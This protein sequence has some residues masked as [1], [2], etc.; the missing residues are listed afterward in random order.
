MSCPGQRNLNG[1]AECEIFMKGNATAL[2]LCRITETMPIKMVDHE[3]PWHPLSLNATHPSLHSQLNN[4]V[5]VAASR[6]KPS[7]SYQ[8]SQCRLGYQLLHIP[9]RVS[10]SWRMTHDPSLLMTYACD[11]LL[12]N[13]HMICT[14]HD[15]TS[16]LK[17]LKTLIRSNLIYTNETY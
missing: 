16:N 1:N 4:C 15:E 5:H 3:L 9:R 10:T 17:H 2:R 6:S 8:V 7:I 14:C 13:T 12:S 11:P